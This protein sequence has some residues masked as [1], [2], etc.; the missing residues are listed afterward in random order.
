MVS[1][2]MEAK[3]GYAIPTMV[4][5]V[6]AAKT[7]DYGTVIDALKKLKG[8]IEQVGELLER[9]YER[10]D[11]SVFFNQIRPYLA[12]SKNMADA[13][14]PRGVFYDEGDGKG[15]W[16]QL[17]GGSNGQSSLIQ[18]FDI[19]LGV[20]H[21]SQGNSTPH[22]RSLSSKTLPQPSFHDEVRDYMPGPHRRFLE[23]IKHTGS[24]RDFAMQ[25]LDTP[26]H[27]KLRNAYTNA[28][29]TLSEF[30][31]KHIRL[32]TRYIVLPS[33]Q[34]VSTQRQNLATASAQGHRDD[35]G[36]TGTGGTLLLPFLKQSRDETSDAA[37]LHA[38]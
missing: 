20:E 16:M 4:R 35:Q 30:R 5:A 6:E 9:M 24:I 25:P 32:V 3:A 34:E 2:A 31:T 19:V 1:V 8:C 26:E 29:D 15:K 36:L 28:V 11:P 14:L 10:S 22:T 13:G 37:N 17:R 33:Q 7:G 21:A 12:G 18:F 38:G 23:Y 27:I